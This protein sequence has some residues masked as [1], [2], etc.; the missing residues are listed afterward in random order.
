[1]HALLPA[2]RTTG[3]YVVNAK[4]SKDGGKQKRNGYKKKDVERE[5]LSDL[6]PTKRKQKY[7][8][9][10]VLFCRD[11]DSSRVNDAE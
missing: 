3:S 8:G 7:S 6:R 11:V 1:M 5:Q 9:N 10:K 2:Q 4:R